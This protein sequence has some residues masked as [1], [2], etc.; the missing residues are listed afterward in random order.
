MF[1]KDTVRPNS[2]VSSFRLFKQTRPNEFYATNEKAT[3]SFSY[4]FSHLKNVPIE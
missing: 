1:Y 2:L 3:R 4:T